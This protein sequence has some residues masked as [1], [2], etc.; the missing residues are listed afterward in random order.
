MA[1]LREVKLEQIRPNPFRD[2]EN[3]PFWRDKLDRLKESMRSTSAWPNIIVREAKRGQYE[4]AFGHHRIEAMRELKLETLTVIV[5]ELCDDTMLKMMCDENAEEFG[6][7]FMLGTMN[8]VSAVKV[9]LQKDST[10]GQGIRVD[11]VGRFLGWTQ[12]DPKAKGGI[13]A[14]DKVVTAFNALELIELGV[15]KAQAF[16][17]L[18]HEQA[19]AVVS[20]AN[21][22]YKARMRE[23]EKNAEAREVAKA[24]KEAVKAAA[25]KVKH[26][27]GAIKEGAGIREIVAETKAIREEVQSVA[28]QKPKPASEIDISRMMD[29]AGDQL[30]SWLEANTQTLALYARGAICDKGS[31]AKVEKNVAKIES[32]ISKAEEK[33]GE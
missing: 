30:Q 19:K 9:K 25:E 4:L 7:N 11:A 16:Q 8:A 18:G 12:A 31:F 13:R 24:K 2:I 29:R 15:C 3:Y 5:E 22:V 21:V 27:V 33:R 17:G 23:L 26:S 28:T 1:E 14:N 10:D 6:T 32:L 20:Q